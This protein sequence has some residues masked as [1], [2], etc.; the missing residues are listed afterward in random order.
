[1][2]VNEVLWRLQDNRT[3]DHITDPKGFFRTIA[4]KISLAKIE[5]EDTRLMVNA[6]IGLGHRIIDQSLEPSLV[7]TDDYMQKMLKLQEDSL[8]FA[9]KQNA[10]WKDQVNFAMKVRGKRIELEKKQK[11][12]DDPD[13][14]DEDTVEWKVPKFLEEGKEAAT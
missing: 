11:A 13:Y 2:N 12:I 1:M 4:S 5:D 7:A 14:E 10:Q 8:N 6:M 9:E 3:I